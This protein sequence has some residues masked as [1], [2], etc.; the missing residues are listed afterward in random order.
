M[1]LLVASSLHRSHLILQFKA[2][3]VQELRLL[4]DHQQ[5]V[6][7]SLGSI[8]SDGMSPAE[9]SFWLGPKVASIPPKYFSFVDFPAALALVSAP[10]TSLHI[11]R[12][13]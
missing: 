9:H 10:A 7:A 3:C 13:F 11:V 8:E 1:A 4:A 5:G 6:E 2:G 12:W